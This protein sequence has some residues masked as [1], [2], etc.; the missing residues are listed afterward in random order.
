MG[1]YKSRTV[2]FGYGELGIA[3]VEAL[4]AA[5]ADLVGAVI[6][7]NRTGH[8]VELF[9]A[10]AE[11]QGLPV[12]AQPPRK[13]IEPFVEQLRALHPDFILVWSYSMILPKTVIEVPRYGALNMHGGIL[14]EYRGGHVLQWA[15]INGEKETGIT[16]HYMDEGI[17]TG[18]VVAES[19]FPIE[20]SDDAASVREKLKQVGMALLKEWWP[21]VSEG[22]AP[23][24]AQ[25]ESRARYY[26]LRT[27]EDGLI[28]WNR[29]SVS[30]YNL[31]RAL[32]P[33][34]PGA[35]TYLK[36]RQVIV[37]QVT[38]GQSDSHRQEYPAGSVV[39]IGDMGATVKTGDGCL[40]I[41]KA[42]VEGQV[43]GGADL[44]RL[45]S[46]GEMFGN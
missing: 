23:R 2:V 13:A 6:P 31:V 5:G 39:D 1:G 29:S 26:R 43:I 36:G 15:I 11:R 17:D 22:R 35:F 4:R 18:P 3:A 46:M 41:R 9:K 45:V 25:D 37:W 27:Q 38:P 10:F 16:L 14:P 42:E 28:D 8:D 30:I 32:V 21:A 24:R 7:S 33:P 20:W 12:M 44:K 19:R 40:V 34:W